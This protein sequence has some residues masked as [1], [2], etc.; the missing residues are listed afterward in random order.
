MRGKESIKRF[1]AF[2]LC[3]AMIITYMP[4]SK[5]AF[6]DESGD[7]VA[8][9]Q[10]EPAPAPAPAPEKAS[11][12]APAPE[13][14]PAPAPEPEKASE[15]EP[16]A[17][18]APAEEA[19]E[20]A[21]EAEP[22]P[23]E[24]AS[25]P[26]AEAEAPAPAA[27]STDTESVDAEAV[28][29]EE[30]AEPEDLEEEEEETYP[31]FSYENNVS[32][33]TVKINAPEGALPEG[34]SA[35][36]TPVSASEIEDAVKEKMGENTEVVKAVDIT[37]YDKDG[38][39]VE[40]KKPISV[41]FI[42]SEIKEAENAA[43]LHIDDNG[44][45]EMAEN[46]NVSGSIAS[47]KSDDFSIYVVVEGKD[48]DAR[49]FVNFYEADGET[50]IA[51]MSLTANQLDAGQM[52]VNIYDPGVGTMV[53]GDVFK[54]W[55]EDKDYTVEDAEDG[56]TIADIRT[57]VSNM[58]SAGTVSDGDELNY[59][60]MM[61]KSYHISYRDELEVTIY[62]DEVL[63]K[64]GDEEIPYTFQFSYT[65]YYVTGSD[66]D[67]ETKAANFD[68]WKLVD[69]EVESPVPVFDNGDE[70]DLADYDLTQS[71]LT[72]TVMAQVAY[73]HWLVFNENGSGATYTEPL[74]VGT[75]ETP[76]QAGMPDPPTRPGYDFD[77]WYTS[78]D[79]T[80]EFVP[81]QP[82]TETT[83]VWAKWTIKE[84]ASFSVLI[85]KESLAGEDKYDF[86][87]S[88][89]IAD[90]T[91]GDVMEDSLNATVGASMVTVDEKEV[92][93]PMSTD[94]SK[95]CEGF[96]YKKCEANTEDGK[97]SSDGSSILNVYFERRTYT[98]KF[99]YARSSRSGN[100]TVYNVPQ[101]RTADGTAESFAG[102]GGSW[103]GNGNTQPGSAYGG[104]G[105]ETRG[106][107][108]YYYRTL[109]AKYGADIS[110]KWPTY[111][112]TD[113]ETWN[114]YRLG[115]WA[116]MRSSQSYQTDHQGT[117][118]GKITTMD[119]Q[120]LGDLSSADGNYV[121]GNYDT[122]NSQYEWTYHIYILDDTGMPANA[123]KL[124]DVFALSHDSGSNWDSQQH[125]PAYAGMT[126]VKELRARVGNLRE[127]N[128]YYE[129]IKYPI[130]FKD[131][132]YENG[133]GRE[134]A[135]KSANSLKTL[136][137][138]DAIPFEASVSR[139]NTYDPSDE[140]P[141]GDDY[142]FLGWY[143]DDK[144]SNKYTFTNMPLDGITVYAK[145]VLKEYKVTLNPQAGDDSS[146]KYINGKP[147]GEY[148]ENGDVIY[149][150]NGE[151]VGNVGGTRDLYDLIGWFTNEGLTKV[152]DFD[153]FIL[154]DTI[155][156]KYGE[157]YDL[158]GS[159]SRYDPAYPGTV[160]EVNLYASW[161][162]ILE[163]ANGIDVVY[164]AIGKDGD[165]NTVEGTEAPTDPNQYSDQAQAIARP[166][167]IAPDAD[168]PLAFQYWVVQKWNESEYIDTDQHVFPGDRFRVNYDDAKEE[169][170]PTDDN[171]D[172][173]KYT[174]Q[175][176]AQYGSAEDA[177]PTHIYWYN[178]YVDSEA[179]I[180][181]KNEPLAINQTV[182]I[183]ADIPAA[184][185]RAGYEFL[186]W[187]RKPETNKE[188]TERYYTVDV[189]END[190]FLTYNS[191]T[192]KYTYTTTGGEAK[193]ATGVFA[194]ENTPYDGMY[195]VWKA[196]DYTVVYT[197]GVEGEEVFADQSTTGK[198]VGD[199]TPAF[200]GSDP[201]REGYVFK[202]WNPSVK[203]KVAAADADDNNVI[204]YTATWAKQ[205]KVTYSY[206]GE[207]P[208]GAPAVPA[209]KTYEEGATVT[210]ATVPKLTGYTFNGWNGEVTTMPAHDV[211]VTGSWTL[212]SHKVTY[213]YTGEV[214]TDA[215]AVPAE[216]TY[217]Y[218]ATVP[219]ATVPTMEGYTFSGWTGEV[220]T[221]PD[222]DVTVTGSWSKNSHKVTY[223]YTGDVPDGAP[224]VPEEKT[225]SYGDT[226]PAAE[227]PTLEGYTFNGWNGEVTTMPDKDVTVTGSWSKNSHKVTYK[228]TGDVPDGAPAV[229]EEKTY[230]YGDTV[231]A[232]EKPTLEGYT[233][234]GWNGEVTTM[235]DKDVTVT[236]SWTVVEPEPEPEPE[237]TTYTVTYKYTGT[238]PAGA[239]AVPATA[240]YAEGA[241]VT[242]AN[243]PTLDGYTFSGWSRTG[244][245]KMP[246]SNVT[247]TGSW[248]A[249]P[250]DDEDED[251][252]DDNPV[253]GGGGGNPG[254]GNRAN[255]VPAAPAADAAVIPDEPVPEAEPEPEVDIVDP[256]PPLA[257]GTWALLNLISAV[258]T[259]LGAAVALFRK[260]EEDDEDE[261]G[262]VNKS[263]DEDEEDNRGK[264]M[265]AAKIAG[266]VAGVAAPITFFLTEDMSLPMAMTDKWTILMVVM[267][268]AQIAAAVFNKK[269][270]ELDE[271]E[272]TA[273][274]AAN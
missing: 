51:H 6:A 40:P 260:K 201:Q 85:W 115:S 212:N 213:S 120:I 249:V 237:P 16:V 174:V 176:R 164:T 36:V 137:G 56:V 181:K 58:L 77:G 183:P 173:K 265:L 238:V 68:G 209:E 133:S 138:D 191:S 84:E 203:P 187:A 78:A 217:S 25:E 170:N 220:S 225:Y 41:K 269:A 99:Y 65:P 194:D 101:V 182:A 218:G 136:E 86:V 102:T 246:G 83:N 256:E 104:S 231:P 122:A 224:A 230:S 113:F 15:P 9:V 267:L 166:A 92:F 37:F 80:T 259:T 215:P 107:Y 247:I 160:G 126:E 19:S 96:V 172:G 198:H 263:E 214:P 143:S 70:I 91:T 124:E 47:F 223:K 197:D 193:T 21:A 64:E 13:P 185:T 167:S 82:I 31:A 144:C 59:Y 71:S 222:N 169:P 38:N 27:A 273:E 131:G 4:S 18:A 45:A 266:A 48:P 100:R 5:M 3:A 8:V 165:G 177:T 60:A 202:G 207:V 53:A 12:P 196:I 81:T 161:R 261:D 180:I 262:N 232:A 153:A 7:D 34:V 178:N 72:L 248:T 157:L 141:D 33:M 228:Y 95:V 156:K 219:A 199:D 135:N 140:I 145:W 147:A 211:A 112:G 186:G 20:P 108:T 22:A 233:F 216:K 125:P 69:P 94:A 243:A 210:A 74:F 50:L 14:E 2:L 229:P 93:I 17:E 221:M 62:T 32:G 244:S 240:S 241:N 24:E 149:I 270:S 150:D 272:D 254:G 159:D 205:Y 163:G 188:K 61:F 10:E 127:V 46:G 49:L 226:V 116:V 66:E 189:D 106:N 227:K 158:D 76:E 88:I 103:A 274:D 258:L 73:G 35:K 90:A 255:V 63:Y 168:P 1:L 175:L 184:P 171:P 179:G 208:D 110:S 152:W 250:A 142:V 67:D 146:F 11:E 57:R 128:Y 26:A 42:S 242:V 79:C 155:V 123:T 162:R 23:A 148:G 271:E 29:A 190:L 204:T 134:L 109:T 239:P 245:F 121:F 235:P 118:K 55:T 87:R 44:K 200:T 114:G 54:G 268:A 236:G 130:L 43:V 251:D 264:K 52:N 195:A 192:G 257:A 111:N 129:R 117:V 132:V 252:D 75:D 98:L 30:A 97:V 105:S 28:E 154:N 253:P 234:N 139:F 89:E 151:K 39:E 206:T 119:E